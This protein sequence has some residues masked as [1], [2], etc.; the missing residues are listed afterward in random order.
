MSYDLSAKIILIGDANSGKT[1][2]VESFAHN[3]FSPGNVCPT[4]GIEYESVIVKLCNKRIKAM[5]WDTAGQESF[6]SLIDGYYRKCAGAILTFDVSSKSSFDHLSFWL[7]EIKKHNSEKNLSI[8][9]AA[10]KIDKHK[11]RV[12]YD[13]EIRAF[14]DEHKLQFLETS[15][16]THHNTKL[17]F[18]TLINNILI[19]NI[20]AVGKSEGIKIAA[21]PLED[22]NRV[23]K[24]RDYCP[25]CL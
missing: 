19:N 1:A 9:V 18:M 7:K 23:Q 6:R 13:D 8:I 16:R 22:I 21:D 10:N 11:E 25:S 12:I 20:T 17:L 24:T 4:I 14:C 15:A 5:I 2:L 3:T